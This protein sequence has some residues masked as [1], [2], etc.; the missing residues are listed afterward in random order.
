MIIQ[1]ERTPADLPIWRDI[2]YGLEWHTL[3]ISPVFFG[4]G[5]PRGDGSAVIVVPG[6]LGTDLH[7]LEMHYW[8]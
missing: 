5:I 7:M 1:K 4:L 2:F 6:F 3:R 8:L